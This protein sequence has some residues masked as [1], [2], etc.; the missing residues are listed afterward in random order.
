MNKVESLKCSD[1]DH[2]PVE[3]FDSAFRS[4]MYTVVSPMHKIF[5]ATLI[6]SL[7]SCKENGNFPV[8]I[9]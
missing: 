5:E 2:F 7:L 6:D 4:F 3:R 8:I 1:H 9:F